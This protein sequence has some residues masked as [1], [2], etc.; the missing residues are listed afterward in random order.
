MNPCEGR[1]GSRLC[2]ALRRFLSVALAWVLVVSS[3]SATPQASATPDQS[4]ATQKSALQGRVA[5][6]PPGSMVRVDLRSKERIRGRLADVSGDGLVVRYAF[7]DTVEE[8]KLTYAEVKSIKRVKSDSEQMPGAPAPTLHEQ[9]IQIPPG[10]FL[11]VELKNKEKIRGAMGEVPTDGFSMK[12]AD[13]DKPW[14]RK[15]AFQDVK[16]VK[17][18]KGSIA[19]WVVLGILG[20]LLLVGLIVGAATGL[21][22]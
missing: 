10:A 8:R 17:P 18:G 12:S 4:P 22:D 6:I 2:P 13:K 7:H 1:D 5:K 3:V 16:A 20:G 11:R 14:E 21:G 19:G 9:I 15:I